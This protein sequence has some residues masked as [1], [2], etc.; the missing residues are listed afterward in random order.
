MK[1]SE[2]LPL[3]FA[4]LDAL[5]CLYAA[6]EVPLSAE[7]LYRS[8][9]TIS[10]YARLPASQLLLLTTTANYYDRACGASE[11]LILPIL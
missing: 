7:A 3:K 1:R 4:R 2:L 10:V 11:R 5:R 9:S 8:T 6:V